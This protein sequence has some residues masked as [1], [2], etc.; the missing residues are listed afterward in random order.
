MMEESMA[1]LG[2]KLRAWDKEE[3]RMY[4]VGGYD[5]FIDNHLQKM[6]SEQ[7]QHAILVP[8]LPWSE[9]Y[10]RRDI[11]K[12]VLMQYIGYQDTKK[13]DIYVGD[14]MQSPYGV[15]QQVVSFIG[16]FH[17]M[18][19]FMLKRFH[20]NDDPPQI[21]QNI[22]YVGWLALAEIVGNVFENPELL[23]EVF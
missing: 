16:K 8:E 9:R 10:F 12:L 5:H 21:V 3:K 6:L 13:R 14:I 22:T 15:R 11:N 1:P 20:E 2:L 19:G 17:L 4:R 23:L 7:L 18:S